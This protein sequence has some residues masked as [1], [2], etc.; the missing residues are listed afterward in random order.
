MQ[1]VNAEFE[2]LEAQMKIQQQERA[3]HL[4]KVPI[5]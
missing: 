2:R 3:T 5:I 1:N 4:E